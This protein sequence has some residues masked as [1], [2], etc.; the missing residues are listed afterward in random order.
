MGD[1]LQ[2]CALCPR[3]CGANREKEPGQCGGGALPKVARAA[4]HHFEEPCL[5]GGEGGRGSGAVFFSGC[6][7]GCVFCQNRA[8]SAGNFGREIS[9][10]RLA[11]IFTEL[12]A[13]GALNINLVSPTHYAPQIRAALDMARPGVRV[14]YNSG[15]YESA[16]T[17]AVMKGAVDV[18]LPDIKYVDGA[19]AGKYSGAPDYFA[20]AS[21]AV[22][23]MA[24]QVGRPVFD[25][26]GMLQRG[27]MIRHLVLPGHVADSLRVL[28][29]IGEHFAPGDVLLSIMSQYTPVAG[30]P[31]EIGRRL[32]R[33]EY[34]RV[35]DAAA[36]LGFDGYVQALSSAGEACIPQFD[37]TGV[38]AGLAFAGKKAYTIHGTC[39]GEDM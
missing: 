7:L 2:H 20:R 22:L 29:W 28:R 17:L 25:A 5:S 11:E 33:R 38:D 12:E 35:A 34:A 24:R 9:I 10:E 31:E 14:V 32:R 15:G 16:E 8:I 21:E 27:V 1:W 4:L 13:A 39:I 19:L 6:P 30:V 23:E 18:Y 26:A 3:Q 36:K 37:L